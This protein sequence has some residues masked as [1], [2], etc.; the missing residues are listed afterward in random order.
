MAAP[1][2]HENPRAAGPLK[3][4][5]KNDRLRHQTRGTVLPSYFLDT[6]LG[7]IADPF[8]HH[9]EIGKPL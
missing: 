4:T 6:A 2:F 7:R 1:V 9:W 5:T 3:Q 8:G